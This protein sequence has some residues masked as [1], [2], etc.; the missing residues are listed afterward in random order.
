[1]ESASLFQRRAGRP[2]YP[3][4]GSPLPSMLRVGAPHGVS[5]WSKSPLQLFCPLHTT[6]DV[7]DMGQ[8]VRPQ[9]TVGGKGTHFFPPPVACASFSFQEKQRR[10]DVSAD[11]PNMSDGAT[12][13]KCQIA[14]P[15]VLVFEAP[16]GAPVRAWSCILLQKLSTYQL[17]CH[18]HWHQ[19]CS[20]TLL[21]FLRA[22]K[23]GCLMSFY[24]AQAL[25]FTISGSGS[26]KTTALD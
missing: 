10:A 4:G 16:P 24:I 18:R 12:T 15:E 2:S 14:G 8:W 20:Q 6:L 23:Q 19:P 1:M 17:L 22:T 11:D 21:M 3:C 26:S 13:P 9:G 25:A 5:P 7:A